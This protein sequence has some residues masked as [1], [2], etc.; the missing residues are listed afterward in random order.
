VAFGASVRGP[1][2]TRQKL[3]NQDAWLVR[4]RATYAVAAISDGLGSRPDTRRGAQAV[5]KAAAEA[6]RAWAPYRQA[7][8]EVLIRLLRILWEIRLAPYAPVNCAATCWVVV[9]MQSGR[10]VIAGLGDGLAL[11]RRPDGEVTALAREGSSFV[12]QTQS[13]GQPH[14]LAD[15]RTMDL[16]ASSGTIVLL[17]TDGVADDLQPERRGDLAHWLATDLGTLPAWDQRRTLRH[18]LQNWPTPGHVDD[19]TL[20]VLWQP[21]AASATLAPE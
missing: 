11:V 4:V 5:C 19:K 1:G 20:V 8:P 12:N 14:R 13:L 17:A 9:W 7:A 3:P 16:M 21:P 15:W 18:E 6:A 2:H 10:L